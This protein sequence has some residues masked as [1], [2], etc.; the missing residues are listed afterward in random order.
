MTARS[1]LIGQK[2]KFKSRRK[3]CGALVQKVP[4]LYLVT[5]TLLQFTVQKWEKKKEVKEKVSSR[6]V[7][8]AIS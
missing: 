8:K 4:D 3:S 6:K 7:K 1:L 5:E 2:D